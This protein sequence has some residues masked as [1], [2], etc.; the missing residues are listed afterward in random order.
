V[1]SHDRAI[2]LLGFF[3]S[4]VWAESGPVRETTS[5][6][7]IGKLMPAFYNGWLYSFWPWQFVTLFAPDGQILNLA[8]QGR[9][10][11]KVNVESVAIHLDGTLAIAW[12]DPPNAG[13][14][15]RDHYGTLI[16]SIDTGR[17]FRLIFRLVTMARCGR[18]AGK[19]IRRDRFIPRRR[20]TQ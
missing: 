3:S 8:A 7:F 19:P 16:R 11:G 13:V 18:L 15:I 14:N 9:G 5:P 6:A 4:A 1:S 20:I 10:N 2:V 12:A 17:S